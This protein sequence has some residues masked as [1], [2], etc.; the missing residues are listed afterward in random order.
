[1][2]ADIFRIYSFAIRYHVEYNGG[3]G[4]GV[5][6]PFKTWIQIYS[7]HELFHLPSN[8]MEINTWTE[9]A[10][11][12]SLAFCSRHN[13]E[14]KANCRPLNWLTWSQ[15]NYVCRYAYMH[16]QTPVLTSC[17]TA[18]MLLSVITHRNIRQG[19]I[20]AHR[21]G[22][23]KTVVP[24]LITLRGRPVEIFRKVFSNL[25]LPLSLWLYNPS[26]SLGRFFSFL[27]YTFIHSW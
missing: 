7:S 3:R 9:S 21:A 17:S 4:G 6:Y 23:S 15:C 11:L 12:S 22:E 1:M 20:Y 16:E 5:L 14:T 8:E 13:A 10:S 19:E 25:P 24:T 2:V 26:L 27:L 18:A